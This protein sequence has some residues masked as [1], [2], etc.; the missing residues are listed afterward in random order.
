[1][2]GPASPGALWVPRREGQ[3]QLLWQDMGSQGLGSISVLPRGA[4]FCPCVLPHGAGLRRCLSLPMGWGAVG[5]DAGSPLF[6]QLPGTEGAVG[7]HTAG[8]SQG[9]CSKRSRTGKHSSPAGERCPR[10]CRQLSGRAASQ[11]RRGSLGLSQ[12]SPCPLPVHRTPGGAKRARVTR[13]PSLRPL[14]KELSRR[15]AVNVSPV[16]A[17]SPSPGPPVKQQRHRCSPSSAPSL[18][19]SGGRS[20]PGAWR[21]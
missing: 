7:G 6:L 18:L 11:E 15:H 3:K 5:P 13:L 2:P 8:V 19:P 9:G 14:E 12:L 21:G 4:S 17:L 16:W 10:G 1:M 20:A